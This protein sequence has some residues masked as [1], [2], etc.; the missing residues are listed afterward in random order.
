MRVLLLGKDGQLGR[1]LRCSRRSQELIKIEKRG[2]S[3]RAG[4]GFRRAGSGADGGGD[5]FGRM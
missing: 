4:G 3:A 2:M 1:A 5:V